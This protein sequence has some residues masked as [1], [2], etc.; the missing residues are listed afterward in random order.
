MIFQPQYLAPRQQPKT[1]A[2]QKIGRLLGTLAQTQRTT[3]EALE[4]LE[5][6]GDCSAD[7]LKEAAKEGGYDLAS[8]KKSAE[9]L[10]TAFPDDAPKAVK[11]KP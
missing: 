10:K 8:L 11:P 2:G 9:N 6:L 4:A 7:E 3:L 1:L 5:R